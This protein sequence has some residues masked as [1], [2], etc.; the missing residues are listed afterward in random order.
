MI[1]P[2]PP[3]K[4]RPLIR[5]RGAKPEL[6]G[7]K[8]D[9]RTRRPYIPRPGGPI[10]C[11]H[12]RKASWTPPLCGVGAAELLAPQEPREGKAKEC[13]GAKSLVLS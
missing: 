2:A 13:P 11:G 5:G 6:L 10:S 12:R 3:C 1:S 8:E 9:E 7:A 4:H